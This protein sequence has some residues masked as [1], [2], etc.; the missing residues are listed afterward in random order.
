MEIEHG[1]G[2]RRVVLADLAGPGRDAL[3]ALLAGIPGVVLVGEVGEPDALRSA[4]REARPDLLLVDDRLVASASVGATK[5]IVM[6]ADDNPGYAAR[7]GRL[8]A[9]A[10]IPKERADSLLP[11][12]LFDPTEV[13]RR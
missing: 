2:A 7:A 13:S 12:L 8:G 6:G 10:W 5:M 1:Q 3:A 9:I 11:A 4:I